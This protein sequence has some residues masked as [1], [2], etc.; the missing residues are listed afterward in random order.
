[1]SVTGS[2]AGVRGEVKRGLGKTMSWPVHHRE[3]AG[4]RLIEST[5]RR[6]RT[7]RMLLDWLRVEYT[8]EK[9]SNKP[10]A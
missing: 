10:R 7:K 4:V 3:S 5:L 9:P 1:M 8:M 6:Q 2:D